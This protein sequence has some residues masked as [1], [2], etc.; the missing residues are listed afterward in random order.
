MDISY[1]C[2]ICLEN[3]NMTNGV[4]TPCNHRYHSKCFFKWIYK[5]RSC[6]LCRRELIAKSNS[7]ARAALN[8]LLRQLEWES[9]LY[10]TVRNNTDVLERNIQE[11]KNE[12]QKKKDELRELESL[13]RLK[14]QRLASIINRYKQ[15]VNSTQRRRRRGL[16]F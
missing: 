14:E 15:F 11:K 13:T 4:L 9:A 12:L 16:L 6:P 3:F 1:N 5:K 2:A 7:E 8:A 10:T